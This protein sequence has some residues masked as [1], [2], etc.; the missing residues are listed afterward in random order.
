MTKLIMT[1]KCTSFASHFED[2]AD[3]PEQYIQHCPMGHAQG[4]PRSHWMP[5][6]GDYLLRIAPAVVRAT[7]NKTT[8]KNGPALLAISMAVAVRR[9]YTAHIA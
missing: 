4:Y 1:L 5:P 6:L 3:V 2:L 9:Y 8:T 7:A